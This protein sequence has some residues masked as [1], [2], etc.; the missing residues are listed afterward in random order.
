VRAES[1]TPLISP[2]I[3]KFHQTQWRFVPR[4][5]ELEIA[6]WIFEF[7]YLVTSATAAARKINAGFDCHIV[8]CRICPTASSC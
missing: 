2:D 5:F 3:K 4:V 1:A 7:G 6:E 8:D